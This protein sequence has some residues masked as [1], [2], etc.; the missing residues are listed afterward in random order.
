MFPMDVEGAL[1]ILQYSL[2]KTLLGFIFIEELEVSFNPR[3]YYRFLETCS[4]V[5][6]GVVLETPDH[7][8]FYRSILR[9]WN[10]MKDLIITHHTVKKYS[11]W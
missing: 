3:V 8:L 5:E 9:K 7:F 10:H 1:K 11:I 2:E 6:L 4:G